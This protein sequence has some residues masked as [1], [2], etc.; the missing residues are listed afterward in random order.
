MRLEHFRLA[1]ND[2]EVAVNPEFV[3]TVRKNDY[4]CTI[5]TSDGSA[6]WVA[7]EFMHVV[8]QLRPRGV[9]RGVESAALDVRD[10]IERINAEVAKGA[11]LVVR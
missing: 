1:D 6:H 2:K 9:E 8:G 11:V 7:H 10:L 5:V 4:G 3:V